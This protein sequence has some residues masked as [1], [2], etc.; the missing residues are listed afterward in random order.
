[1][2]NVGDLVRFS[3]QTWVKDELFIIFEI[4]TFTTNTKVH[5]IAILLSSD[6]IRHY[7]DTIQMLEKVA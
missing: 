2:V 4:L 7:C 5:E 1:M 6:G 3:P